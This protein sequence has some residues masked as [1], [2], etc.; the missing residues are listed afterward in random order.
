MKKILSVILAVCML[1]G[2][3][4]LAVFAE[5]VYYDVTVNGLAC[6][7]E[8]GAVGVGAFDASETALYLILRSEAG[9]VISEDITV[10]VGGEAVD[11]W[12]Y[13]AWVNYDEDTDTTA[14]ELH[15]SNDNGQIDGDIVI[16]LK[17]GKAL[18]DEVNT[19]T[20]VEETATYTVTYT[21]TAE[22]LYYFDG[23]YLE[24]MFEPQV[25][26]VELEKDQQ[27]LVSS[28][29]DDDTAGDTKILVF[30][31]GEDVSAFYEYLDNDNVNGWQES[32]IFTAD[33]DGLYY[34]VF[35]HYGDANGTYKNTVQL[36][37]IPEDISVLLDAATAV[38]EKEVI[39]SAKAYVIDGSVCNVYAAYTLSAGQTVSLKAD[40]EG[41]WYTLLDKDPASGSY[42]D[43]TS[44]VLDANTETFIDTAAA[45]YVVVYQE[46]GTDCNV[47]VR[48]IVV[49]E[50]AVLDFT[51]ADVPT[52]DADAKWA[53][54]AATKT[55]T[56]KEGF[57]MAVGGLEVGDAAVLLPADSTVIVE[58]GA[59]F[60]VGNGTA[61][62]GEGNLTVKGAK[63]DRSA[64]L[65]ME[66]GME[67]A[68]AAEKALTVKNCSMNVDG[69][70]VMAIES[71]T[72]DNISLKSSAVIAIVAQPL[73]DT[74]ETEIY[75]K[76]SDLVCG[77]VYPFAATGKIVLENCVTHASVMMMPPADSG[78]APIEVKGGSITVV[79]LD[80]KLDLS[81]FLLSEDAECFL[82]AWSG[83]CLSD[84]D[85]VSLP[86][87]IAFTDSM[88]NTL[89]SGAI[90][91]DMLEYNE[92]DEVYDIVLAESEGTV[93]IAGA[94]TPYA[95]KIENA[96]VTTDAEVYEHDGKIKVTVKAD[97]PAIGVH[98]NT[99][100]VPA[101][102]KVGELSGTFEDGSNTFEIDATLLAAG[103]HTLEVTYRMEIANLNM[104]Y[105]DMQ[106]STVWWDM[107]EW[108]DGE[109]DLGEL[110]A[111]TK[112]TVKAKT[113]PAPNPNPDPE[114][115]QPNDPD[116]VPGTPSLPGTNTGDAVST[117]PWIMLTVVSGIALIVLPFVKKRKENE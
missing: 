73:D 10:T 77:S 104:N 32:G 18:Q 64:S 112:F 33:A 65:Y 39:T 81:Q 110:V 36:E 100:L 9:V 15:I 1:C 61:I 114:D 97:G 93:H 72:V 116:K 87:N 91:E 11:L 55:L 48:D 66:T 31:D 71:V 56:L 88:E 60:F 2:L 8:E 96:A 50:D 80:S 84:K 41:V 69:G 45:G 107:M 67:A 101:S 86:E 92:T 51:A 34:I 40:G 68:V 12:G 59:Y 111:S 5:A 117:L 82:Y 3:V 25:Y 52:P 70:T 13:N 19:V 57:V 85:T 7:A 105:G 95:A 44:E 35:T 30:K 17:E 108:A 27:V 38:P 20:P 94:V 63:E 16:T 79:A 37:N 89:Y 62:V 78:V 54:D 109:I 49:N 14:L 4:P 43:V 46:N 75:C 24:W 103:E 22:P 21:D 42:E 99:R 26:A 58:G 53:W 76:N 83:L 90:T 74:A 28:V 113:T 47:T 29:S 106:F 6:E 102:W 23:G 98:S 115:N